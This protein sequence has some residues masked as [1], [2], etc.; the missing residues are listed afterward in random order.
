LQLHVY[1]DETWASDFLDHRSVSAY[2]DKK[3]LAVSRSNIDAELCAMALATT[4]VIWLW[5]LLADF[6][7][8]MSIPTL[9][10]SDSTGAI[11]IVHD[12]VKHALTKH[13]GINAY[14]RQL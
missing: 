3:K 11:S 2:Y 9:F 6:G 5:W 10:L 1:Y 12:P 13:I 7:V 4:Y 8:F 14:Y